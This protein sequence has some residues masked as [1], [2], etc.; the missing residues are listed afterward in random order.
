MVLRK[1]HVLRALDPIHHQDLRI[2]LGAFGASPIKGLFNEA[3]EPSLEHRRI[4]LAFNYALKLKS[5]P[6]DP[7]HD[8][9]FDAPFSDFS[10]GSKSEPNFIAK[11]FE[12][13]NNAKI[14]LNSID[15]QYVQCPPPSDKHQVHVDISLTKQKKEDTSVVAYQQEFF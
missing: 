14:S 15:N 7:C 6:Q 13:N 9:V 10:A 3:G 1:K 2:T 5:L 8:I 12:H 4:K 11:T